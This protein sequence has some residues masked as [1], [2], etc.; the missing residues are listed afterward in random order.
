MR[1]YLAGPINECTDGQVNGWRNTVREALAGRGIELVDPMARDYRGRESENVAGIVEGD[2]AD[3]ESCDLVFAYCWKSS[4]GTSMEIHH[5]WTKRIAVYAVASAP[6]SPWLA[7]HATVFPSL[8][9]AVLATAQGPWS[10]H[11]EKE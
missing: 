2:K 7:Y 10:P 5:A 11:S 8:G 4:T 3:I 1:V 6:V 9:D